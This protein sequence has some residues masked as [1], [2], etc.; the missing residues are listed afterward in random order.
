MENGVRQ[1]SRAACALYA[2]QVDLG[3][4]HQNQGWV[5]LKMLAQYFLEPEQDP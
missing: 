2:D 4:P 5:D 1:T 3:F